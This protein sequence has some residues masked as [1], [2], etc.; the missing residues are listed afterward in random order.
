M[1]GTTQREVQGVAY[2]VTYASVTDSRVLEANG[3][4]FQTSSTKKDPRQDPV[5]FDFAYCKD[6][7]ARTWAECDESDWEVVGGS[8]CLF[9][10]YSLRCH[11]V[12]GRKL[13]VSDQRGFEHKFDLESGLKKLINYNFS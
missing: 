1:V 7:K 2:E 3:F 12:A 9:S 10:V 6:R 5:E 13:A 11:V 4:A 8:A